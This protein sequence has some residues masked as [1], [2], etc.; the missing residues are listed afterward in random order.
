MTL[1]VSDLA[2]LVVIGFCS[3]IGTSI[4]SYFATEHLIKRLKGDRDNESR[5]R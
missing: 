4:G 1:D 3:G 2:A 5:T